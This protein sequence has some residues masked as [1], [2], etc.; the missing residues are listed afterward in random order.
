MVS[1]LKQRYNH[2]GLALRITLM[3]VVGYL[4]L[5][6]ALWLFT[7]SLSSRSDLLQAAA[8]WIAIGGIVSRKWRGRE[9]GVE[10]PSVARVWFGLGFPDRF[11]AWAGLPPGY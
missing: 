1:A 7:G 8:T 11:W 6:A 5:Q 10:L 4:Y 2:L 9:P 3:C